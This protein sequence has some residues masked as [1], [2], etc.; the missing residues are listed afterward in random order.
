MDIWIFSMKPCGT[1]VIK[2][3]LQI[4]FGVSKHAV[5]SAFDLQLGGQHVAFLLSPDTAKIS[6]K[7]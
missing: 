2:V 1:H 6:V 3:Y 5:N 4:I 7:P